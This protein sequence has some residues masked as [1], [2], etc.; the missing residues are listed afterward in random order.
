MPP[1]LSNTARPRMVPER[2]S[3]FNLN[4][5]SSTN[6]FG[7]I[8]Y[9]HNGSE[10]TSDSF[11]YEVCDDEVPPQ[12]ATATVTFTINPVNDPPVANDDTATVQEDSSNNAINVAGNDTDA[13]GDT[14]TVSAATTATGSVTFGANWY[15]AEAPTVLVFT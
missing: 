11:V 7:T 2:A 5:D 9:T 14:L 4:V 8:D 3:S 10:T 13:D 15:K 1:V 6:N 12:C